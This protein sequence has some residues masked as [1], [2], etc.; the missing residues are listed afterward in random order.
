[1]CE[2]LKLQTVADI[3]NQEETDN[4]DV[5]IAYEML[6]D[7]VKLL[8]SDQEMSLTIFSRWLSMKS[9]QPISKVSITQTEFKHLM[10]SLYEELKPEFQTEALATF[11]QTFSSTFEEVSSN[12]D[13]YGEN[14]FLEACTILANHQFTARKNSELHSLTDHLLNKRT[15]FS[16]ESKFSENINAIAT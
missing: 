12:L 10:D 11:I 1:M 13:F 4:F 14:Q 15:S 3:I 2:S 16:D 5:N 9:E 8:E 7:A 6:Q